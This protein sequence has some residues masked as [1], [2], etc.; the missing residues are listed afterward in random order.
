MYKIIAVLIS[1][2]L[3]GCSNIGYLIPVGGPVSVE[4]EDGRVV[5]ECQVVIDDGKP[6][7]ECVDKL[8][9]LD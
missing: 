4:D 8:S 3:Y 1:I 2:S 5:R 9:M 6:A 7:T